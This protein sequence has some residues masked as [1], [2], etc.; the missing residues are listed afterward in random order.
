VDDIRTFVNS[1]SMVGI[2]KTY[3]KES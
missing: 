1:G 2:S 3:H